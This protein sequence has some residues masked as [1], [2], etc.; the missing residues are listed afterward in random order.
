METI[1]R[2]ER[3]EFLEKEEEREK[4][5]SLLCISLK[6]H[7]CYIHTKIYE[8]SLYDLSWKFTFESVRNCLFYYFVFAF[9]FLSLHFI[10]FE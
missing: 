7:V 9:G 3:M 6:E 2:N 4:E 1:H 5:S 8:K 10:A